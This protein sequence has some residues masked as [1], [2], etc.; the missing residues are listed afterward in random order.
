[1]QSPVQFKDS[2]PPN[3]EA[4]REPKAPHKQSAPSPPS[5]SPPL[6]AC[7]C[8]GDFDFGFGFDVGF[9]WGYGCGCGFDVGCG[10]DLDP[11]QTMGVAGPRLSHSAASFLWSGEFEGGGPGG[12]GVAR[13]DKS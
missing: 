6:C 12:G 4:A 2:K 10:F 3:F 9:G 1:M 13:G 5:P 8:G 11:L 7:S